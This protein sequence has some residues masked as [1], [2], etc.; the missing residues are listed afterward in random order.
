MNPAELVRPQAV[1]A[2]HL[3][4][5]LPHPRALALALCHPCDVD[6]GVIPIYRL[7]QEHLV[8]GIAAHALSAVHF[9]VLH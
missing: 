8:A 6:F 3:L 7:L 9:V 2:N 4:S 5:E 1:F